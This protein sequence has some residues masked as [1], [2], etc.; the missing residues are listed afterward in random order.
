MTVN[1]PRTKTVDDFSIGATGVT[2]ML[3]RYRIILRESFLKSFLKLRAGGVKP[4][5][6]A[7]N[8]NL[9]IA[10]SARPPSH[11]QIFYTA[12]A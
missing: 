12:H 6:K 5:I 4:K 8:M 10:A 2:R 9:G 3:P 1:E 11:I 7:I